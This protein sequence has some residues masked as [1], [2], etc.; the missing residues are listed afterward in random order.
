MAENNTFAKE[1]Q[2]VI[3]DNETTQTIPK[4]MS[5]GDVKKFE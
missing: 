1:L 2:T 4:K 3:R 5:Q